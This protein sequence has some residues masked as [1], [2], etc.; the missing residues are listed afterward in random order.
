MLKKLVGISDVRT[1]VTL[2]MRVCA[3]ITLSKRCRSEDWK[4]W[5]VFSSRELAE[6]AVLVDSFDA[7]Q[8][9]FDV[10]SR[11]RS[12]VLGIQSLSPQVCHSQS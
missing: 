4:G 8:S 5:W 7:Q 10:F 2:G 1:T 3:S 12:S 6:G 11:L 9:T